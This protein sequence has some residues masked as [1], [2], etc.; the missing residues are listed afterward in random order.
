V[1]DNSRS[2]EKPGNTTS[3]DIATSLSLHS[4]TFSN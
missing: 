3:I 4:K 2:T 1:Y